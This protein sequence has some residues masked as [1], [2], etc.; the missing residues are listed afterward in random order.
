MS[1]AAWRASGINSNGAVSRAHRTAGGGWGGG[2][3][4]VLDALLVQSPGH[5]GGVGRARRPREVHAS[6]H[7]YIHHGRGEGVPACSP[8]P[9]AA[10]SRRAG[11]QL[12]ASGAPGVFFVF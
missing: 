3:R 11:G 5:V 9:W 10:L 4:V 6:G 8:G 12:T 1:F 7:G 2:A